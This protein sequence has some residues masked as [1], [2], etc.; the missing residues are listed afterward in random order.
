ME[1]CKILNLTLFVGFGNSAGVRTDV[2]LNLETGEKQ[3]SPRKSRDN[4]ILT[5]DVWI[6]HLIPLGIRNS[7]ALT[8][9]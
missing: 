6:I 4:H 8:F 7:P 3:S 2:E 1:A 9:F 5:T